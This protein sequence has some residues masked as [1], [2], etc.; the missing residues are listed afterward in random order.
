MKLK[1]NIRFNYNKISLR[2]LLK[3]LKSQL[4][5]DLSFEIHTLMLIGILICLSISTM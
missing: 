1:K 5:G 2:K 4:D 3:S